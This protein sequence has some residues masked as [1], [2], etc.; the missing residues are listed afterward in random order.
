MNAIIR[1]FLSYS[2]RN[3]KQNNLNK[4]P[5]NSLVNGLAPIE[6]QTQMKLAPERF[7]HL[8]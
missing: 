4:T 5:H 1:N 2:V 3:A 6:R 8:A 7:S